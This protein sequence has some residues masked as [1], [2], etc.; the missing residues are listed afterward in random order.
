M[1]DKPETNFMLKDIFRRNTERR[2]VF[3]LLFRI[4]YEIRLKWTAFQKHVS[5]HTATQDQ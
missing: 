5:L 4:L 3:N 2:I 1:N